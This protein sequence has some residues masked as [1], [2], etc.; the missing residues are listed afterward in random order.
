MMNWEVGDAVA[1]GRNAPTFIL[2]AARSS[3]SSCLQAVY[4]TLAI[5]FLVCFLH[6]S[7]DFACVR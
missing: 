7:N 4:Q 2:A 1:E 6:A 3:T 5:C